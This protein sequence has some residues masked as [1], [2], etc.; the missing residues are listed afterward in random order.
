MRLGFELLFETLR[1]GS[2]ASTGLG[3][4]EVFDD[5]PDTEAYGLVP[6]RSEVSS[7]C[8]LDVVETPLL[9]S[10][11][12]GAGADRGA[13][14]VFDLRPH[15]DIEPDEPP[16]TRHKARRLAHLLYTTLLPDAPEDPAHLK[17][18]TVLLEVEGFTDA[19]PPSAV[20]AAHHSAG[21]A[22]HH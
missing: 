5:N 10:H 4:E 6:E 8:L 2:V 17:L 7:Q 1:A 14:E 22:D 13:D 19:P 9:D 18:T 12:G 3:G 21:D 15:L 20:V 16:F 11:V